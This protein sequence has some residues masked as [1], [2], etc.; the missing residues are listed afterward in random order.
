[1]S[2][3]DGALKQT[4]AKSLQIKKQTKKPSLGTKHCKQQSQFVEAQRKRGLAAQALHFQHCK[5]WSN[6]GKI[7]ASI[8]SFDDRWGGLS[9]AE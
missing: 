3:A 7:Y 1:M 8:K 9:S 6:N 4:A 2:W 5:S